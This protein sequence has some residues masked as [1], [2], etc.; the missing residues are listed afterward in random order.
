MFT[1]YNNRRTAEEHTLY[2]YETNLARRGLDFNDYL[3]DKPDFVRCAVE[4]RCLNPIV[5]TKK[6]PLPPLKHLY[7]GGC[8]SLNG[9]KTSTR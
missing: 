8:R 1:F 4:L 9:D 5:D 2:F 6:S 7:V 3:D